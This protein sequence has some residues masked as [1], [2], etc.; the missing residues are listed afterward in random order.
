[1]K[2]GERKGG[3]PRNKLKRAILVVEE[4]VF[5]AAKKPGERKDAVREEETPAAKL[6][7]PKGGEKG[8]ERAPKGR[9]ELLKKTLR[10]DR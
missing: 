8:E 7:L 2:E 6:P 5:H 9:S 3:D 1:L 4:E 10:A